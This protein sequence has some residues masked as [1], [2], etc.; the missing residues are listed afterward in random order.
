MTT[1]SVRP[2]G[3][4]AVLLAGQAPSVTSATGGRLDVSTHLKNPGFNPL[5]L[6]YASLASCIV[7]SARMAAHSLGVLD[8]VHGVTAKVTG[9]KAAEAPSRVEHFHV[10]V[11]IDGDIDAATRQ[12]IVDAAEGEICTVSN[13]L[14]GNPSI[15]AVLLDA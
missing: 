1:S 12:K 10:E 5:D 13:T 7:L 6:L 9:S 2:T 4:T 3:A 8:R 11:A 15:H 14:R